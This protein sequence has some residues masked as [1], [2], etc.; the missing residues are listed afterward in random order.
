MNIN[1]TYKSDICIT[2]NVSYDEDENYEYIDINSSVYNEICAESTKT[3]TSSYNPNTDLSYQGDFNNDKFVDIS[4]VQYLVN[5]LNSQPIGFNKFDEEVTYNVNG[6]KYILHS[7]PDPTKCDTTHTISYNETH[8]TEITC[9]NKN[10]QKYEILNTQLKSLYSNAGVHIDALLRQFITGDFNT[11]KQ[12]LTT[13]FYQ[14][15]AMSIRYQKNDEYIHY[16]QLRSLVNRSLEVLEQT[17]ILE[18]KLQ[19]EINKYK[20]EITTLKNPASPLFELEAAIRTVATIKP[21]Y[22]KYIELF[23]VPQGGVFDTD[24]LA[25]IIENM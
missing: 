3:V 23:G 17:V 22:V 18:S 25:S 19:D 4:D 20:N 21:E 13:R 1:T 5:W 14:D 15:M 9:D 6:E 11:V 16:E 8:T 7:R 2:T 12:T 24:K 10:T